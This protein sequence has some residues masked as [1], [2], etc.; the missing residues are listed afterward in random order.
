MLVVS[1]TQ[2]TVGLVVVVGDHPNNDVIWYAC[3]LWLQDKFV[4]PIRRQVAGGG[5]IPEGG[6]GLLD[7]EA[8]LEFHRLYSAIFFLTNMTEDDG[9][10]Q[11]ESV[12]GDGLRWG[13]C[14]LVH[15]LGQHSRFNGTK[16]DDCYSPLEFFCCVPL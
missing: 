11:D 3:V 15:V 4:E 8:T 9:E 14:V 6:N 16:R 5:A 7:A 13:G 2:G 1:K 12:F 10:P